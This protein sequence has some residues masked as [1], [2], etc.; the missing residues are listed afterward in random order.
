MTECI[1]CVRCGV[2]IYPGPRGV[3]YHA[4]PPRGV[5]YH[6]YGPAEPPRG[7][8]YHAELP[9][10]A[11]AATPPPRQRGPIERLL[12]DAAWRVMRW[13]TNKRR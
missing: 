9:V 7:V 6:A 10:T 2:E 11:H 3:W 4:E 1:Y 13:L 12:I 5:W 8:W